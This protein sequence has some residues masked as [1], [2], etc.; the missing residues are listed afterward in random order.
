MPGEQRTHE[1]WRELGEHLNRAHEALMDAY[2]K[3]SEMWNNAEDAPGRIKEIHGAIGALRLDL[4]NEYHHA[5]QKRAAGA[6]DP[7]FGAGQRMRSQ[8]VPLE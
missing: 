2:I 8:E 5:T 7:I 3:A 1:D 4:D 6:P